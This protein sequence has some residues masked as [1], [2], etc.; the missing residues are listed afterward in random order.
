MSLLSSVIL[1]TVYTARK[2]AESTIS[3]ETTNKYVFALDAIYNDLGYFPMGEAT[4]EEYTSGQ[5]CLSEGG[6]VSPPDGPMPSSPILNFLFLNY[7]S[8][9]PDTSKPLD[10]GFGNT[11][12]G[13]VYNCVAFSFPKCEIVILAYHLEGS[14]TCPMP[15][16]AYDTSQVTVTGI[17]SGV[18][19]QCQTAFWAPYSPYIPPWWPSSP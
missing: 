7:I 2:K 15:Q 5:W 10:T 16:T 14:V 11:V 17:R 12:N 18:I 4:P 6:C 19:T 13:I 9:L 1:S 3:I 8:K